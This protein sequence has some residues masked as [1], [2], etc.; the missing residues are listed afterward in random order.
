MPCHP[1][2]KEERERAE[3]LSEVCLVHCTKGLHV[4]LCLF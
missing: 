1:A 2:K 4:E 3:M